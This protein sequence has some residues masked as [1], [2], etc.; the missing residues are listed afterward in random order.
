M[1]NSRYDGAIQRENRKIN[2]ILFM[3]K[4]KYGLSCALQFF[5]NRCVGANLRAPRLIP[6]TLINTATSPST[7]GLDKCEEIT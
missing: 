6:C 2:V 1:K 5:N 4:Y 3:S 7:Q